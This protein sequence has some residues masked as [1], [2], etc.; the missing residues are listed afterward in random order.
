MKGI[1]QDLAQSVFSKKKVIIF[2][3]QK[4]KFMFLWI[5]NLK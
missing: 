4:I 5:A 2:T 3:A 1:E